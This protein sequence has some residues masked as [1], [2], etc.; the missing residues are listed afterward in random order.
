MGPFLLARCE[1]T[2]LLLQSL[3]TRQEYKISLMNAMNSLNPEIRHVANR[4]GLIA[5]RDLEEECL[6]AVISECAGSETDNIEWKNYIAERKYQ[7]K[8]IRKLSEKM[9]VMFPK[10]KELAELIIKFNV[11]QATEKSI[12]MTK[13]EMIDK[14]IE[15]VAKYGTLY[16]RR[17]I[18]MLNSEV[19]YE[20]YLQM[21]EEYKHESH[22][23][24]LYCFNYEN[25]QYVVDW[26]RLLWFVFIG[27]NGGCHDA[28]IIVLE[29]IE[30]G[31]SRPDVTKGIL[32]AVKKICLDER[33]EKIDGFLTIT[34]CC[35][36]FIHLKA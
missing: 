36:L 23:E 13:E 17:Y 33:L 35:C 16:L 2:R 6:Y 15:N 28:D 20:Y 14:E 21:R 18:N 11:T 9:P 26:Y 8:S 10:M 3:L 22:A 1:E 7:E 12:Q 4:I 30:Y 25:H 24:I 29:L 27:H 34:G 5:C 32:D 19:D 31:K